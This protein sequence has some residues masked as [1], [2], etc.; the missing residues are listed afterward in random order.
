MSAAPQCRG[1]R[2]SRPAIGSAHHLKCEHPATAAMHADPLV[3]AIGLMGKRSGFT[4]GLD[5]EAA[6]ALNI[7]GEPH[8][9]ANGWFI[10][11]VNF[12]PIWLRRCD[13][14]AAK[15]EAPTT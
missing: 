5:T 4:I 3:E 12:D 8:G 2:F 9:I 6:Q 1:C 13:G 7:E 10:W 15:D 14:F 11:P